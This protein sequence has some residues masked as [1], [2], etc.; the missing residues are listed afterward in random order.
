MRTHEISFDEAARIVVVRVSGEWRADAAERQWRE[1]AQVCADRAVSSILLD[2]REQSYP[3]DAQDSFA[4]FAGTL[5]TVQGKLVAILCKPEHVSFIAAGPAVGD[6][7]WNHARFFFE[8]A[9]AR[10]WLEQAGSAPSGGE[11]P[12]PG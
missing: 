1:T 4:L 10:Q 6:S 12:R 5:K 9:Q 3:F 2:V 8:E 11:T 7:T